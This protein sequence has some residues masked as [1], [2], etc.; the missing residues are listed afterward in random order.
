MPAH[1]SDTRDA[2]P[3]GSRPAPAGRRPE[4]PIRRRW[5]P[6]R[7]KGHHASQFGPHP[8]SPFRIDIHD[9]D[10]DGPIV[11][12]LA[13]RQPDGQIRLADVVDV[14]LLPPVVEETGRGLEAGMTLAAFPVVFAQL[15]PPGVRRRLAADTVV[16][17]DVVIPFPSRTAQLV[18]RRT[19]ADLVRTYIHRVV[20]AAED[21]VH[22][23]LGHAV[24]DRVLQG[25]VGGLNRAG[26]TQQQ[27]AAGKGRNRDRQQGLDQGE[28]GCNP[29][30]AIRGQKVHFHGREKGT[31][32]FGLAICRVIKPR[33]ESPPFPAGIRG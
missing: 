9:A 19:E 32:S 24:G 26:N 12:D 8:R 25:L 30:A 17:V 5:V 16:V 11:T 27:H 2:L 4:P 21:L 22:Q 14:D 10:Y 31:V 29:R 33:G 15:D 20:T 1:R 28:G 7:N 6:R 23:L 13:G 3:M 18:R